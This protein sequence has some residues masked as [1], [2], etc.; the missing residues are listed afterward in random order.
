MQSRNARDQYWKKES[1]GRSEQ[2]GALPSASTAA[3]APSGTAESAQI[4]PTVRNQSSSVSVIGELSSST[5][6]PAS[7]SAVS[8][9]RQTSVNDGAVETASQ[10]HSGGYIP[11][12]ASPEEQLPS[13]RRQSLQP[14]RSE[15]LLGNSLE[16]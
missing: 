8:L 3:A 16:L 15:T 4:P 10:R 12:E 6:N 9:S 1:Q 11:I 13:S 14:S 5:K 2:P 7:K